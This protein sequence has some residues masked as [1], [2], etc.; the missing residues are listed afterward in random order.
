MA[1][2]LAL[3]VALLSVTTY[4]SSATSPGL[5]AAVPATLFAPAHTDNW[6]F[7]SLTAGGAV[8]STALACCK[9]CSVGDACGNT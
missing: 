9:V 3:L 8:H 5:T 7:S 2:T 1:R 6:L 4:A